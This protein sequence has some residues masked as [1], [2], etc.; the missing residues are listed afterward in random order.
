MTPATLCI[1]IAAIAAAGTVL[2]LLQGVW[3][4]PVQTR[5]PRQI[6]LHRRWAAGQADAHPYA[7][8][9]LA[10]GRGGPGSVDALLRRRQLGGVLGAAWGGTVG[11]LVGGVVLGAAAGGFGM[12]AGAV[13]P[14]AAAR[15]VARRRAQL[16]RRQAPEVLALVATASHCGLSTAA[17]LA[18]CGDWLSSELAAG[19]ADA[20]RD[21]SRGAA[22]GPV[23]RRLGME[24]PVDE[25][26]G[27]I[28]VLER[29]RTHGTAVADTLRVNADAA[30]DA[31][32]RAAAE[33]AAKA[34]PRIQLVAALLLVPAALCM[35][36]A[37]MVAG[38]L[39]G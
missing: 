33:A 24:F 37:A 7:A 22:L 27:L 2:E 6:P 10:A 12:V 14:V 26:T 17:S 38:G 34:A 29:A 31:R 8:L 19:C 1:A 18:A 23:L 13:L 4:R 36:A 11:W 5:A 21:L 32:A 9:V 3:S 35:L 28:A 15:A 16:L 25:V 30:R 20:A 39:G